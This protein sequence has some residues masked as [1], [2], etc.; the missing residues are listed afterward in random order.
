MS[1]FYAFMIIANI[2]FA[3]GLVIEGKRSWFAIGMGWA[4]F[5]IGVVAS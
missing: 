4:A 5:I 3:A 1:G 2:W